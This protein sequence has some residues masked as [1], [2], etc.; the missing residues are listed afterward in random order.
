[1]F[2]AYALPAMSYTISNP[3]GTAFYRLQTEGLVFFSP[4]PE[5]FSGAFF[6][7]DRSR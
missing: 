7:V 2:R 1:M 5:Y 3:T 6:F 4:A